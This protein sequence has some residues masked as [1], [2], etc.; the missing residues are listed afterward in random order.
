MAGPVLVPV[1]GLRSVLNE[2]VRSKTGVVG[3]S[4][5]AFLI[6]LV[7]IVPF[8][9]PF[10]VVK[11]W[12]DQS[13]WL[14]NPRDAAPEWTRLFAGKELLTTNLV[15][16]CFS[17]TTIPIS[18]AS[19]REPC[20]GG[21]WTRFA[22]R[23]TDFGDYTFIRMRY[24]FTYTADVFPTELALTVWTAYGPNAPLLLV[25]WFRPDGVNLTVFSD[26]PDQRVPAGNDYPVSIDPA[27][28]DHIR[29]WAI[30]NYNAT[31]VGLIAPEVTL[32]AQA[33]KDM[34]D[35]RKAAVLKGQYILQLD[36]AAAGTVSLDAK[37]VVFG[38]VFGIAGTDSNRRDLLIGLLWGAPVALAFGTVAAVVIVLLQTILGAIATWFGGWWDEAIQRGADILLIL[39]ILPILLLIAIVYSPSIWLILLVLVAFGFVGSTTKVARS[40]VLQVKEEAY[41]EAAISYGA[42]RSRILFKHI[43]PRLMPYTFA[44]VALSVPSFIFLE[45][46]LSFLGLGDPLLPTWGSILGQAYNGNAAFRGFWWWI[47]FPAGG[48]VFATVAFALLGYS[49]DKVLNPRL[50]EQ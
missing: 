22:S 20:P 21:P 18:N 14:D 37:A 13:A 9:A 46:S 12:R 47:A 5:L 2:V 41:I 15:H 17:P 6:G 11:E 36:V 25:S 1:T 34:L 44:L 10:D 8:V 28:K 30:A 43:L 42:S 32:F 35:T 45:A 50:R 27:I 33:G 19:V 4:M 26:V 24:T 23:V 3:F 16:P 31:D 38:T 40:I 48:I 29:T 7:L 39:P 49:F